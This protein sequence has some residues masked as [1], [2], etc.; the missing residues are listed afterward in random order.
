MNP[1]V[2]IIHDNPLKRKKKSG[3]FMIFLYKTSKVM[4]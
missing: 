2:I 4:P 3:Y 1:D